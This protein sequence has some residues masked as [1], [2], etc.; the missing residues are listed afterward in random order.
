[1]Q[2]DNTF[3]GGMQHDPDPQYQPVNTYRD[4]S[5][6]VLNAG[7]QLQQDRADAPIPT[8]MRCP[9]VGHALLGEEEILLGTDGTYSEIGVQS[10]YGYT[11]LLY[12][13][14]F[15][16]GP[17]VS[18][19]A[20]VDYRG[21]RLLY[22][23]DGLRLRFLD[24]DAPLPLLPDGLDLLPTPAQPLLSATATG[25]SGELPTGLYQASLSLL[26][27]SKN[28]ILYT[29]FTDGVPV[30][31]AGPDAERSTRDGAPPQTPATG[32]I[33]FQLDE[34]PPDYAYAQLIIATYTGVSN[35]LQ[36]FTLPLIALAGR[37][38]LSFVY[39]SFSQHVAPITLGAVLTGLADYNAASSLLQKDG[40]LLAANVSSPPAMAVDWQAIANKV[41]LGPAIREVAYSEYGTG[42]QDYHEPLSTTNYR[43]FQRDEVYAF[44][45]IPVVNGRPL[46]AYHIPGSTDF[47]LTNSGQAFAPYRSLEQYPEAGGYPPAVFGNRDIMHHRMPNLTA[48]PLISGGLEPGCTLRILGVREITTPDFSGLAPDQLKKLNG[49]Y[50]GC[51]R[52]T[53]A[54]KSILAQGIAQPLVP[55]LDGMLMVAPFNGKWPAVQNTGGYDIYGNN[56]GAGDG[57]YAAFYSPETQLLGLDTPGATSLTPEGLLSGYSQ[58][59]RSQ[60]EGARSD[61]F[62]STFFHY[63]NLSPLTV[64]APGAIGLARP[65]RRT[66]L[67][68]DDRSPDLPEGTSVIYTWQQN[69][70]TLLQS[71]GFQSFYAGLPDNQQD[72][73]YQEKSN[74]TDV[75]Y[76]RQRDGGYKNQ[77]DSGGYG[78]ASRYLYNLRINR[79]SQY[80]TLEQATYHP[81]TY[82]AL[83]GATP[84]F[85]GGD[86]FIS[87]VALAHNTAERSNPDK[88]GLSFRSLSYF[89]CE[90][91]LNAAYR[92]YQPVGAATAGTLPYYPRLRTL[93]TDNGTGVMQYPNGL[94]HP[95]GYNRQ[96]SFINTLNPAF[97][98]D[99]TVTPVTSFTNRVL[100]SEQAV[101][102]E[103]LD[104]Y[105]LFRA[106]NY[107]DL[108]KDKGPITGLWA[109]AGSLFIHCSQ[110]L[111]KAYF[112]EATT[113]T[114]SEGEVNL[115]NGGLFPRPSVPVL[116][117]EGG[118]AGCQHPRT[119]INTPAG[120]FFLDAQGKRAY[121][122]NDGLKEL[123]N[124]GLRTYFRR[125]LS[126]AVP[127]ALAAYDYHEERLLLYNLGNTSL[128][129]STRNGQWV[130]F[131]TTTPDY[132]LASQRRLL[133]SRGST[134]S[135]GFAGPPL[136]AQLTAISNAVPAAGKVF[137][138]L[139]VHCTALPVI[140]GQTTLTQATQDFDVVELT[141]YG[142]TAQPGQTLLRLVNDHY[143]YPVSRD[144]TTLGRLKG[145]WL[146]STTQWA[147]G[148][149][150][151]LIKQVSAFFRQSV[152]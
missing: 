75:V 137:D 31:S 89:F 132:A 54:N 124:L 93:Y 47:A 138:S 69:G 26:S 53:Q 32:S 38:S 17:Q 82:R 68:G 48:Q 56:N 118:Y 94:G 101:E 151:V 41:V 14:A 8:S 55:T 65:S 130:S 34:L 36:L 85:F 12:T 107:H 110:A 129:Y 150:P 143:Q 97:P 60:R 115:G 52:R 15:V 99:Y 29:R 16:L 10:G 13:T 87:K 135:R 145:T 149:V 104:A 35:Q 141:D 139:A 21:H 98:R 58:H 81:L 105:R 127:A 106:N 122:F 112:N 77:D 108:P 63:Y 114:T 64:P 123:S 117:L 57:L 7:G 119:S 2:Q 140:V 86:T 120:H 6:L 152:R 102:G 28:P 76:L 88:I 147:A 111:Y 59:V 71:N 70:Y 113:Q 49:Y 62:A 25:T 9:L 125:Q 45:L 134:L 79:P 30:V 136:A 90:S 61:K 72:V 27:A 121:L 126:A 96:Y 19:T 144:K 95:T 148:T 131:H 40:R 73:Y 128:S 92:H 66:V 20:R 11:Q 22:F 146:A 18:A 91:T 1:M 78:Q 133:T 33:S 46:N 83:G 67:A 100:Y 51:Q 103:Q 23:A 80:G 3:Q 42:G 116:N 37:R 24:L 50:I 5:N 142:Q 109:W 4:A 44:C 74:A 43:G 84:D 39:S